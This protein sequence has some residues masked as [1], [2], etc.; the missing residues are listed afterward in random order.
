MTMNWMQQDQTERTE[1]NSPSR[2]PWL[3]A[4]PFRRS[5]GRAQPGRIR[6]VLSLA[7]VL[8]LL[9]GGCRFARE[10]ANAPV[11]AVAGMMPGTKSPAFD[12]A[13]L[14]A[15]LQRYAD[16]YASR[17]TAALDDY[18]ARAGTPEGR[19]QA[20]QWKVSAGFAA[21][22]IASGPNPRANLLDFLA[23][24]TVTRMALEDASIEA[25]NGPA[26]QPWLDTSRALETNAWKLAGGILSPAQQ[27][28]LRDAI[29]QWREANPGARTGIFARP[30]EFSSLIRQTHEKSDWSGSVFSLVGLDPTA[31]LDPA[32]RE[33]T[34][35]RLFAERAMFMVERM[36]FLVR[37]QTELL[38]D[39]LLRQEQVANALSSADRLSQT[40]A[41]LPDR[42]TA[43]RKAI[44]EALEAQEGKLRELSAG[45]GRTLVAGEKMSTSLNTTIITFDALMK[46]FGVGEPSTIP[47]DTNSPPFNILDYARTAEQIAAMAQ[48]LDALLKDAGTA[49]DSPALNAVSERA[50]ADARSVLNHAFLLAAGLIVLA[51]ACAWVY[52]RLVPRGAAAPAGRRLSETDP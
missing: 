10:T 19:H 41:Q 8:P 31:G 20:L 40:A 46:R 42:I 22:G 16:E 48:Q 4:V 23:L 44:L 36:P 24:A 5:A 7:V 29:S 2:V 1:R 9:L 28:E 34:R 25:T 17:T 11:K 49:L 52:R 37:W 39:E 30:Q 43:E 32:V 47:P 14:Q 3:P 33:V 38:A 35:T 51:F 13:L 27:Q 12:P 26:F 21:V 18:A 50:R 15:E 45:I 6:L